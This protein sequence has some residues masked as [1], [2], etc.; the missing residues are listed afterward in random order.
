MTGRGAEAGFLGGRGT[1]A[2][3]LRQAGAEPIQLRKVILPSV[4]TDTVG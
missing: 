2:V 3:K 1:G 4:L